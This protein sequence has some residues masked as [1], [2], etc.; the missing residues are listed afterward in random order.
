[1]NVFAVLPPEPNAT[2]DKLIED[3]F[4]GNCLKIAPT[5]WLVAGKATSREVSDLLQITTTADGRVAK[6]ATGNAVVLAVSSYFGIA[7]THIWEWLKAK[8]EA[9]QP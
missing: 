4:A 5:Q 8:I 7:Q 9:S 1:M 6:G 3:Q 2:L